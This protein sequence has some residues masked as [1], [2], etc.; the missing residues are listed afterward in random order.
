MKNDSEQKLSISP[1]V[2][3][4]ILKIELENNNLQQKWTCSKHD[5]LSLLKSYKKWTYSFSADGDSNI[6][7]SSV[8]MYFCSKLN[9]KCILKKSD[10]K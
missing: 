8:S 10:N 2:F 9:L 5:F 4:R 3:N 7:F 6:V 1:V